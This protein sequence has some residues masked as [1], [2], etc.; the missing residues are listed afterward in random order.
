M[1][2]VQDLG[3]GGSFAE[4]TW[5]LLARDARALRASRD[6]ALHTDAICLLLFQALRCCR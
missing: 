3:G 4:S 6:A 5:Q 1:A 2:T